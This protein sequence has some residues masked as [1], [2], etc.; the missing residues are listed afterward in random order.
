MMAAASTYP[1]PTVVRLLIEKGADVRARD[2]NGRSAL[3]WALAQGETP[4]A[5]LLRASGAPATATSVPAPAP[6]AR[7]RTVSDAIE[8]AVARLQPGSPVFFEQTKCISCH[9]QSLPAIVVRLASARGIAVDRKLAGHP[10]EAT[11]SSWDATREQWLIGNPAA[12]GF[13]VNVTYGL[14]ALAEEG[15]APN[16]TT[17]AAAHLLAAVQHRDGSWSIPVGQSGGGIRPPLGTASAIPAT[18]LAIRGLRVYSSPGM[19]GSVTARLARALT[20]LRNAAPGDTQD[21]SFKLLGLIWSEAPR[22]EIDRQAQRLTALQR[23]GGEWSQLPTMNAD[24]Y[25]TGQALY[26][27]RAS[28]LPATSAAY[29][30]GVGYL[31][32]T[33]LEDGTWYVRSRGFGFQPYFETGFPHGKDQFISSAA[34]SWAA[35]ALTYAVQQPR[36]AALALRK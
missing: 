35:I 29:Q 24:A 1:D 14:W 10:T 23:S 2:E 7:P 34:T 15:I 26:A 9:H 28:G 30:K 21:E 8:R 13:V 16:R 11:L 17:D 4:V 12:G 18:A 31:L 22:V 33:Q 3:D 25:A 6:V 20:F 5:R 32:R 27:L 36:L 19:R